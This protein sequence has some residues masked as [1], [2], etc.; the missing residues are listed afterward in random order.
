[1]V[2]STMSRQFTRGLLVWRIR[3]SKADT[4]GSYAENGE[5]SEIS[6]MIN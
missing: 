3:G 2:S 4:I 5:S 6:T 1:M